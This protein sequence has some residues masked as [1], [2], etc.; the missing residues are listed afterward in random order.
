MKIALV[1]PVYQKR[2]DKTEKNIVEHNIRK[3]PETDVIIVLASGVLAPE[4]NAESRSELSTVSYITYPDWNGTIESYNRM[5]LSHAFYRC[6]KQYEY[7]LLCQT[8]AMIIGTEDDL[9]RFTD[10]G[11]DYYGAPFGGRSENGLWVSRKVFPLR[12]V[13]FIKRHLKLR[14]PLVVGNGGFSLRKVSATIHILEK[15]EDRIHKWFN[16]INEDTVL[17]W[18]SD[19]DAEYNVCPVEIAGRF[20][21]DNKE[22]EESLPFGIHGPYVGTFRV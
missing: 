22:P 11:Y 3:L 14:K 15:Y 9:K 13:D 16:E 12:Q 17:S 8:D 7:I 19:Y 20:A 21:I 1:I 5:C 10:Y 6:F 2:L 4:I 18:L